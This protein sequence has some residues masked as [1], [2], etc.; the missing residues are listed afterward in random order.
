MIITNKAGTTKDIWPVVSVAMAY[1]KVYASVSIVY[2]VQLQTLA[3]SLVF[4]KGW[5]SL[6]E[7]TLF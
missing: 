5:F 4:R 7:D 1:P 6:A 3:E 2:D